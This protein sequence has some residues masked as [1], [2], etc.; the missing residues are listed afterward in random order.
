MGTQGSLVKSYDYL[1]KFLLVGDRDVSKSDV[2]ESLQHCTVEYRVHLQQRN[3]M[4]TIL[5]ELW[6]SLGQGSFCTIFRSYPGDAR[7]SPGV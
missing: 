6:D 5:L 7:D 1:L 4:T 3:K 2:L